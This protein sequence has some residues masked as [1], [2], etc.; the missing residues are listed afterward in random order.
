MVVARAVHRRR[1]QNIR[2][3][4]SN[5]NK[6]NDQN[7]AIISTFFFVNNHLIYCMTVDLEEFELLGLICKLFEYF[8]IT[9]HLNST[10]KLGI[11]NRQNKNQLGFNS[12]IVD[13]QFH[14]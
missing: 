12:Q 10:V 2:L 7:L 9:D 13:D 8:K 1:A 5:L 14:I 6:S 11:K 3:S 4:Q